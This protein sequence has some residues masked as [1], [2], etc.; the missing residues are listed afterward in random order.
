MGVGTPGLIP[1]IGGATVV[2]VA[3]VGEGEV[4]LSTIDG[5]AAWKQNKSLKNEPVTIHQAILKI[6]T[7]S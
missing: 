2:G 4:T 6:Q 7:F 1:I 5:Q 3:K